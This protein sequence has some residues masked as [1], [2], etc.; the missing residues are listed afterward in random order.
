MNN[1]KKTKEI[2]K[3]NIQN[4]F[5][6]LVVIAYLNQLAVLTDGEGRFLSQSEVTPEDDFDE[7]CMNNIVY[8]DRDGMCIVAEDGSKLCPIITEFMYDEE[9][10][11]NPTENADTRY[12]LSKDMTVYRVVI[13]ADEN[14][15][16]YVV[17]ECQG[18]GMHIVIE[19]GR[20]YAGK[21]N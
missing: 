20:W 2:V 15:T 1:D 13:P 11:L 7:I 12:G 14:E 18:V 4:N 17:F 16:P 10:G 9:H 19:G 3:L 6:Q 8:D 21:G 5:C